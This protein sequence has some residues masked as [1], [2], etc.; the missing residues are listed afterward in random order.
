[1]IW[2]IK[3]YCL[4]GGGTFIMKNKYE[5]YVNY[6]VLVKGLTYG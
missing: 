2:N 1:M 3:T 4:L 5:L 6:D